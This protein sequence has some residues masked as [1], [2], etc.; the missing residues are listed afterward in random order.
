MSQS[1]LFMIAASVS[2]LIPLVGHAQSDPN[3]LREKRADEVVGGLVGA[4]VG[5]IVGSLASH[6][7]TAATIGAG[8]GGAAAGALIGGAASHCGQ[9]RYG[10]YDDRRQWVSYRSTDYG[11]VG[12][13]G[14]W[15][16]Q[17]APQ[18]SPDDTR[19][20]E[21]RMQAELDQRIDDGRLDRREGREALRNLSEISAIDADYRRD[22]GRL[23]PSQRQDIEAR[24]DRLAHSTAFV[25]NP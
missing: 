19:T 18:A 5:V 25:E 3:C 10:Y 8:A 9:N 12:P 1:R 22:D 17:A 21:M 20:R 11:Y 7:G 23:S 13:D 16:A 6:G 15:V 14:K 2:A 24:L 4:G